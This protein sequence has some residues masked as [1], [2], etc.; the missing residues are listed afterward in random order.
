[1]PPLPPNW[2]PNGYLDRLPKDPVGAAV[3]IPQS[4]PARRNRRL[5][6]RRRRP[7][8]RHGKRRRHR[9]VGSLMRQRRADARGFTLIEVLV[10][11]VVIAHR[12]RQ[13]SI[14]ES[15]RRRSA[16]RP[17]ARQRASPARSSTRRRLRSGDGRT[18]GVSAEG[19]VYRF[20]RRGADDRWTTVDDDDVLAAARAARRI[21]PCGPRRTRAPRSPRMSSLPF[22]P[23]GRNEPYAL[24]L[25]NPAWS[26][27]VAGDPLNRVQLA[28][29]AASR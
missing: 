4:G 9:I 18:L 20:W 12:C 10:V 29:Q 28:A 25:A 17:S 11:V 23:S 24:L 13:S 16:A 5:Q 8:G 14:V 1:M 27:I 7:A 19:A 21:S 6:L 15:R 2:K 3:S 22:R 26:V